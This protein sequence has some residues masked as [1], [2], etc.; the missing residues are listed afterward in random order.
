MLKFLK[1]NLGTPSAN[2]KYTSCR[3]ACAQGYSLGSPRPRALC[4]ESQ[5]VHEEAWGP[6]LTSQIP[7]GLELLQGEPLFR[8]SPGTTPV[9]VWISPLV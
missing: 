6:L 7:G 4:W 8:T 1:I 2:V 5:V 9:Y 3:K